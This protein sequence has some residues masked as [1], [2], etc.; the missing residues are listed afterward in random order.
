MLTTITLLLLLAAV[1]AA[2]QTRLTM[3][4]CVDSALANN[5]TVAGGKIAVERA[6]ELAK[7]AFELEPTQLTL[8]Q[9]PTSGGSP[10]NALTL[11]QTFSLPQVYSARRR[12]L[13][14]E[15]A[16]ERRRQ[17]LTAAETAS[18]VR[19]AYCTVLYHR[20]R[21]LI[22]ERAGDAY[23]HF[24]KIAEAR[25]AAGETGRLERMNVR[26]LV[27]E[28][29]VA[30]QNAARDYDTARRRLML[31]MNTSVEVEPA[32]TALTHLSADT[33]AA[34]DP[35]ST[36]LASALDG[37]VTAAGAR[38]TVTRREALPTVSLEAGAQLVV[39]GFNPYH[40]DR[41]AYD[42]GDFMG[43]AVGIGV[44]LA[45][46]THKA[47]VRA[48]RKEAELAGVSRQQRLDALAVEYST[49]IADYRK[50]KA[51]LD[52]YDR[53]GL[54]HADDMERISR[55]AYDNGEIGYIELL[56]NMQSA[57]EIRMN[58]AD[59]AENCNQAVVNIQRIRR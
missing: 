44:P 30:A 27:E 42:K 50:A 35:Q 45:F 55:A 3:Q 26:R 58:H 21:R 39:K 24:L 9:D 59:A 56:Q 57:T 1:P 37:E 14:A 16:T 46:G 48:A 52:Y 43:F 2:A 38:V 49:A 12:L 18:A 31:L 7:T 5:L 28:N 17:A 13:R 47:K 25:L 19:G 6:E 29:R 53:E 33:L 54:A 20:E 4:A 10:D 36:A 22:L 23:A 34:F 41:S 15:A 40:V 51:V 32:D 8:A 11:S